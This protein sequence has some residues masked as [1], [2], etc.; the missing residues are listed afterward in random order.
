[1]SQPRLRL[2]R[3]SRDHDLTAFESGSEELD[4][5]LGR[6]GLAAQEMDT[7]RTFLL[8]RSRRVVGYFSL[9][10]G[11][12]LREE[13]P[14]RLVRG[15]PAYP[16]GMVLLARLAAD[17]RH[18]GRG[19]GALLLT[20]ALRKALAAGESAA[21]RLVVVDAIDEQAA[22]FY[23]HHGFIIAPEHRHRLYRRIKDIKASLEST[24]PP[25][26]RTNQTASRSELID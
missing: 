8:I 12:V 19:F 16:V 5:W 15:M 17:R 11:S 20:E 3:L 7:A 25:M 21:A 2:E 1:M 9:T 13:A 6:H 14:A 23:R 22:D 26:P 18:Q 10:M 24:Q 4:D